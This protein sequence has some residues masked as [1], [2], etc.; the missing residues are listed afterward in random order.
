LYQNYKQYY[1][2]IYLYAPTIAPETRRFSLKF[3]ALYQ[4]EAQQNEKIRIDGK[5]MKSGQVLRLRHGNHL[6]DAKQPYQ[7]VIIPRSA[8]IHFNQ[9]YQQNHFFEMIKDIFI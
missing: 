9:V 2:S 5:P 3:T 8:Q 4:I 7:I 6:S 1:G